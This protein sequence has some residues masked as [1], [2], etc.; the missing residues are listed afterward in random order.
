M[1]DTL[2]HIFFVWYPYVCLSSFIFGSLIR[3]TASNIRGRPVPASC[4]ASASCSGARTSF[5][6]ASCSC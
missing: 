6:S 5:M 3:L 2:F 1:R 4:C